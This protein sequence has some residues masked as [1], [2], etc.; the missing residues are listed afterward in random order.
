MR[1]AALQM[2]AWAGDLLRNMKTIADAALQAQERGA[3]LLVAPELGVIGYGA[4]EAIRRWTEPLESEAMD[5]LSGAAE[6]AEIAIV[7]GFPERVGDAVYNS[8]AL[9]TPDGARRVYR[10]CQLYGDYERE[11]FA[12]GE[13]PPPLFELGGLKVGTL[14]CYDVEFP[15]TVRRLAAEGADLIL[16]PTALPESEHAAFIAEKLVPVRAFENQVAIVYA[17]HAG[18]DGRFEY[19]G[20]SCIVMPDGGDA[21]RAP[22]RGP[23]LIIAD[24][25]P[26]RHAASR[27][28]NPYL[29]D[30]RADLF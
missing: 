28:A 11:L 22:A 2:E 3:E 29:A 8:A 26:S 15:E 17:N 13:G 4:E 16:V 21:A 18:M 10:K 23:A 30:R 19:A 7:A 20:R 25:E 9:V 14:I 1:I 12:P 24:Y 5:M 6:F 27:A